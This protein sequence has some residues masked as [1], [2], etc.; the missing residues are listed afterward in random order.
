MSVELPPLED[1]LANSH[2]VRL[3][4]RVKFRGVTQRE[5]LLINGPEGWGE[6]SAFTEYGPAEASRWLAAG[7]E[8]AYQP[9]PEPLRTSIPVNATLPAVAVKDVGAVLERYDAPHTIKIKVAE[10]G[11]GIEQ[12]LARV[13][14]A[15][16]L[17]PQAALRVDANMGWDIAQAIP[18]LKALS[19]Y[20]LQYAEQPVPGIT[21]LAEVREQLR[22]AGNP[23]KIAADEA[24]RKHTDPLEVSRL[25]AADLM[26]I[27]AQPLGGIGAV[28]EIAKQA[29]LDVVVSSALDTSVGL[30]QAAALA[31]ALPE[32]PYACGLATGT[33]FAEDVCAEPLLATAGYLPVRRIEPDHQKLDGLRPQEARV[34]WWL[35]RLETCYA[36]L[37][38]G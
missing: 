16:R 20:D 34:R 36:E 25:G 22:N 4:M 8:A 12:D 18:A 33:L 3:P 24:V 2:V 1:L 6:F 28:L 11:Q 19:E 14:E 21:G 7:I 13:A 29:E 35:Q 32:L 23:L 15:R 5:A 30:A 27:K 9:F 10:K 17:Y 26:V 38:R 31:S 37:T